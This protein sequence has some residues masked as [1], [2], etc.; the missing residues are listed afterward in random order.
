MLHETL[1][2]WNDLPVISPRRSRLFSLTPIGMGTDRQ[3]ALS[4]Y[5]VRLARA[6]SVTPLDLCNHE[7]LPIT[8]IKMG[9]AMCNFV[10]KDAKTMNGLNKYAREAV[11]GFQQLTERNDLDNCTLLPWKDILDNKAVGL[12]HG[13]PRWCPACFI[14]WRAKSQDPYWPLLWFLS[15]ATQ[16]PTHGK[17]LEECCPHCGKHQPFIPRHCHM[18]YC[19]HCGE[20]L[21]FLTGEVNTRKEFAGKG[22]L[23]FAS[24]S[25]AEMIINN[26]LA[27]KFATHARMTEQFHDLIRIVGKGNPAE[28]HRQL[29]LRP[30]ATTSWWRDGE[31]PM[32]QSLLVVCYRLNTSPVA[33]LSQSLPEDIGPRERM[34]SPPKLSNRQKLSIK[35]A[36]R[37]R[38]KLLHFQSAEVE[39]LP[40]IKVAMVL[41]KAKTFLTYWFPMECRAIS[42]RYK[43]FCHQRSVEKK[44]RFRERTEEI[45]REI[46]SVAP[47][48]SNKSV[49]ARLNEGQVCYARPEAREVI[50]RVRQEFR[51]LPPVEK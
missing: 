19:S 8:E 33:F 41:G 48:A 2:L 43:D 6:H 17:L 7:L 14:E 40:M 15:P 1:E 35:D 39:A 30:K 37:L 23:R 16:C 44:Q 4:S 51:I 34:F 24:E 21:A 27:H 31:R 12:L 26:P 29:G 38:A 45:A 47:N 32:V 5:M 22:T 11:K 49:Q 50:R 13:H 42:E 3:E 18:D 28:M 9:R 20:S 36:E 10:M 46:F 25:V